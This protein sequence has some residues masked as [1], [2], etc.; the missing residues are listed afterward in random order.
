MLRGDRWGMLM[1]GGGLADDAYLQHVHQAKIDGMPDTDLITLLNRSRNAYQT[2][3]TDETP[4]EAAA[5]EDH[6]KTEL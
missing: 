6:E 3:A 4:R 1:G 2:Q 5:R